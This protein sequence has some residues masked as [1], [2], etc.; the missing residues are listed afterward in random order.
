MGGTS[1]ERDAL[2]DVHAPD[3]MERPDPWLSLHDDHETKD[4]SRPFLSPQEKKGAKRK[5][6]DHMALLD[7][8]VVTPEDSDD[9]RWGAQWAGD[10]AE[11]GGYYDGVYC[12][13]AYHGDYLSEDEVDGPG[14]PDKEAQGQYIF[15]EEVK[16][17]KDE[18]RR[19]YDGAD[20]D[21]YE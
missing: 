11:Q 16:K 15:V 2:P 20:E 17:D 14:N 1:D 7:E 10:D 21:E 8:P 5:I 4:E 13:G 18:W 19:I 9:E 3:E 12:P 6:G